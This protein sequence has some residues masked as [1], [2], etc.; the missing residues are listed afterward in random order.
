MLRCRFVRK[1]SLCR[2][3]DASASDVVTR[4][5]GLVL[6]AVA[7]GC[8]LL[9]VGA[10]D[11]S[12]DP[13]SAA[14]ASPAVPVAEAKPDSEPPEPADNSYCYVC[15]ANYQR[16]ELSKEHQAVGVGCETCHGMSEKHS[17]DEDGLIPPEIMFPREKI[18]ATCMA[19]CHDKDE[20]AASGN[21]DELF[22]AAK[23]VD[24]TCTE[25]HAEKHRLKV[26][27][28]IW[29]KATGKLLSDDGVRMMYKDSPAT[30]GV[31]LPA[32]PEPKG[33]P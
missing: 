29:D 30:T 18:N 3:P 13:P 14:P 2:S 5:C 16:E 20:L 10:P 27:T 26:R 23:K 21:H 31:A 12:A 17:G 22:V 6:A 4:T 11:V 28:R 19:K 9:V 24:K 8:A 15:H 25:C 1:L 7:C 32:K 33:Q